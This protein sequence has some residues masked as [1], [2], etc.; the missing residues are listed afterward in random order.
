MKS[1]AIIQARMGSSRLPGKVL[2]PLADKPLVGHVYDRVRR[3]A[4]LDQVLIA[5]TTQPEDDALA[6]YCE[7][8]GIPVHRGSDWDVL[9]RFYGAAT[10]G[11][12]R[13]EVIVRITADCPLHHG[14]VV[15]FALKAFAAAGT[16]Y[17]SNSNHEP[18][19]L[20]DGCD[21]EVFTF[22]ALETAWREA[23]LLS[24]REHVTPFIKDSGLFTCAWQK[25]FPDWTQKLSV[26]TPADFAAAE[27]IFA[28][29]APD[30]YFSPS[31]VPAL[32]RDRPDILRLNETS[33]INAGYLKSLAEDRVIDA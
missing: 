4:L 20:E 14:E 26:D 24:Q 13:P 25:A 9:D 23:N 28:A 17:F 5:T 12:T 10:L 3:S 19:V 31:L 6:A 21:T 8:Q 33:V 7:A 30:V 1:L 22:V 11:D 16:D 2:Q 29:F 27:A 15:D 32:L 18:D